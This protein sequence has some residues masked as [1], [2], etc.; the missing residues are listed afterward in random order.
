[1]EAHHGTALGR[2]KRSKL[3]TFIHDR[4]QQKAQPYRTDCR[5][6][7]VLVLSATHADRHRG[8]RDHHK[9]HPEMKILMHKQRSRDNR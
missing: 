2:L 8:G 9:Q 4:S 6:P 3:L 5:S 7:L 1:M